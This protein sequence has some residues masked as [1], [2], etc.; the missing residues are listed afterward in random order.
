M[1]WHQVDS[2]TVIAAVAVAGPVLNTLPAINDNFL[3]PFLSIL[4]IIYL[5]VKIY[6]IL[7]NKGE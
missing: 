6:F 4:G 2:T 1:S 3:V 5:I 7:K